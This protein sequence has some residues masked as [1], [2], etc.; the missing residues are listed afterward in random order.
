MYCKDF[1]S[2]RVAGLVS[3]C[4]SSSVCLFVYLLIFVC[5]FVYLLICLFVVVYLLIFICLL[6]FFHNPGC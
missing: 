4:P 6:L 5:L 3:A 2:L 1:V